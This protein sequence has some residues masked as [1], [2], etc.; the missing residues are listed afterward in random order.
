MCAI[1][2]DLCYLSGSILVSNARY[3]ALST[4]GI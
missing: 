2:C 1:D 3:K 4:P